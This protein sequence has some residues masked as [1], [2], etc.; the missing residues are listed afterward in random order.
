MVFWLRYYEQKIDKKVT[1]LKRCRSWREYEFN[2]GQTQD[3]MTIRALFVFSF[4]A[5]LVRTFRPSPFTAKEAPLSSSP[6]LRRLFREFLQLHSKS[7]SN[8]SEF[9]FRFSVFCESISEIFDRRKSLDSQVVRRKRKKILALR[10]P[11][12]SLKALYGF[13][14]LR[15]REFERGFKGILGSLGE[16]RGKRGFF[17][18][19][20]ELFSE[21]T[22]RGI[23]DGEVDVF[24][25]FLRGPRTA[26]T[27]NR[28]L[29]YLA[30]RPSSFAEIEENFRGISKLLGGPRRYDPFRVH[31]SDLPWIKSG[32]KE[33]KI[34][35]LRKRS[36]TS[37][38]KDKN[39]TNSEPDIKTPLSTEGM[40]PP[41]GSAP[42]TRVGRSLQWSPNPFS[43]IRDEAVSPQ[44]LR[45]G[46]EP[47]F[48]LSPKVSVRQ[49]RSLI[50]RYNV[51]GEDGRG[52]PYLGDVVLLGGIYYPTYVSWRGILTRV[53]DINNCNACYAFSASGTIEAMFRAQTG[54]VVDI[55]EQEF[56]DCVSGNDGCR[57]GLPHLSFRYAAEN[58][59]NFQTEYPYADSRGPCLRRLDA[60]RFSAVSGFVLLKQG[61]MNIIRALRFGPVAAVGFA[62]PMLKFHYQGFFSGQGCSPDQSPNHS[63]TI[64]GY[65]LRAEEPY[66]IAKNVWGEEWGEKGF[67]KFKIGSLDEYNFS[68]CSFANT[69]FNSFV[70]ID[71]GKT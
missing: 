38:D 35:R 53:K 63:F 58:R 64:V 31:K 47:D 18:P 3:N 61:V 25:E 70:F 27:R 51:K 46:V 14:D 71:P 34:S 8:P 39:P 21:E 26:R 22:K 62:S 13:A 52:P 69:T 66:F 6:E 50:N 56:I 5:S 19:G 1:F 59:V 54:Q 28:G 23:E 67:F 17:G 60:P 49:L 42:A 33:Q 15:E 7:Y 12:G 9:D 29:E 41:E 68:F 40:P 20:A 45:I 65:N 2:L 36:T 11:D 55:S 57:G 32:K 44:L 48:A 30:G 24:L 10:Q 16:D 43:G 37:T 4:L